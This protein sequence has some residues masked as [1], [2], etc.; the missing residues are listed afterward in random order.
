MQIQ[1]LKEVE[2]SLFV[3]VEVILGKLGLTARMQISKPFTVSS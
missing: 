1:F 2:G 3:S